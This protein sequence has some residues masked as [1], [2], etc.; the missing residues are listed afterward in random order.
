[1]QPG[2]RSHPEAGTY[3]LGAANQLE[4][5]RSPASAAR[6]DVVL[7]LE[8]ENTNDPAKQR[9]G[10]SGH[11]HPAVVEFN[12][13]GCSETGAWS[14]RR[15]CQELSSRSWP[16]QPRGVNGSFQGRLF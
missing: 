13:G 5:A 7:E 14:G 1:M 12:W 16:A 2:S 6:L 3:L 15:P 8:R 11:F 9:I 10:G 4:P